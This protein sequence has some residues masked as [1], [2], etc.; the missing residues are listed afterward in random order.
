MTKPIAPATRD[1][2][3]IAIEKIEDQ[4]AALDREHPVDGRSGNDAWDA[5]RKATAAMGSR[6]RHLSPGFVLDPKWDAA[7]ARYC[8]I[9]S[10]STSG[11]LGALHNWCTAARKRLEA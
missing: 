11:V 10:T 2:I 7:V 4:I 6:I 3:E 5:Y 8:G 9:R 1:L